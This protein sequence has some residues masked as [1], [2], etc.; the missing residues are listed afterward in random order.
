MDLLH[1]GRGARVAG[2]AIRGSAA[3]PSLAN[4]LTVGRRDTQHLI[5]LRR[6][7]KR[8]IAARG[9][10]DGGYAFAVADGEDDVHVLERTPFALREEE[11]RDREDER[12]QAGED[13]VRPPVDVLERR[14]DDHDDDE[15]EDPVARGRE[16][17]RGRADAEADD[18]GGLVR[19]LVH[20]Q[21]TTHSDD[22][23]RATSCRAIRSRRTS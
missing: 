5:S 2:R 8:Q 6:A 14:P 21:P 11:V 4:L 17:V 10:L 7:R 22:A 18:L 3:R 13:D 9:D 15:V 20:P 1:A 23:R 12:V 16:R 19:P